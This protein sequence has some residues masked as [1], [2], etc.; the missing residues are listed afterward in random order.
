M[1]AIISPEIS[2]PEGV[3]ADLYSGQ[4]SIFSCAR[5]RFNELSMVQKSTVALAVG[6]TAVGLWAT[7]AEG[8]VRD[9]NGSTPLPE[10]PVLSSGDTGTCVTHFQNLLVR[11]GDLEP[12]D[13]DGVFGERTVGR[14]KSFQIQNNIKGVGAYLG[15][16][17]AGPKTWVAARKYESKHGLPKICET[18]ERGICSSKEEGVVRL[19]NNHRVIGTFPA[20]FGIEGAD[21]STRTDEGVYF[22]TRQ[23]LKDWSVPYKVWLYD[24]TYYNRGEGFHRGDTN[25]DSHG[26]THVPDYAARKIRATLRVGDPVIVG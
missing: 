16:G 5:Q 3:T 10:L 19:K 1:Q 20:S 24:M 9:C 7:P 26:C 13:V 22:V 8:A 15:T 2:R 6:L 17:N 23:K 4:L 18:M 21:T 12:S 14:T 11:H 25:V